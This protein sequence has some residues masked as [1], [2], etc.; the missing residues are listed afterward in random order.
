MAFQWLGDIS[1]ESD[2]SKLGKS[3]SAGVGAYLAAKEAGQERRLKE[4][5]TSLE[6]KGVQVKNRELD[7]QLSKMDYDNRREIYKTLVE[8]LPSVPPEKQDQLV[9]SPEFEKLEE[10]LGVPHLNAGIAIRRKDENTPSW[11]Q[12]QDVASVR[13]DLLRGRGVTKDLYGQMLPTELKTEQDALD[14]LSNKGLDPS[15]FSAELSRYKTPA[16]T[17]TG[18]GKI[19]VRRKSDGQIGEVSAKYFNASKY[20][21]I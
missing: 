1:Q 13:A 8:I 19:I 2:A 14:Y 17:T 11:G 7:L 9:T 20:E 15:L 18:K 21:R 3:I 4:R 10:S 16:P 12:E 6:E 5:A